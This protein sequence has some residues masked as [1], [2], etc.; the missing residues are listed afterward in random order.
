MRA[1][2]QRDPGLA[3][4][5]LDN[6]NLYA[7]LIC[8]GIHVDPILV[9]IFSRM[10]GPEKA[11]LI[12]DGISA[13]GMPDGEYRLGDLR[14]QVHDGRC[15]LAGPDGGALAGSVLT[16]DQAIRNFT[17]FTGNDLSNAV[18]LATENPACMLEID[19]RYGVLE[20][21]RRANLLTL[22]PTGDVLEV[23]LEGRPIS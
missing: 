13:T 21:G 8:D 12:T 4:Y 6:E 5:V 17:R 7:E 23:F 22:S 18:P 10:K 20:T 14:V 16:L 9:R 19:G 11:I 15:M 3:A 1:L 2:N